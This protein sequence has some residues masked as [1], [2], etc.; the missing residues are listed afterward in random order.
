V[1]EKNIEMASVNELL[2]EQ[3]CIR[4]FGYG[5]LIWK[6]EFEYDNCYLGYVEGYERRFWQGNKHHRGNTKKPG[7]VLTLAKVENGHCWGVVFEITGTEKIESALSLLQTREC[8]LGGYE[9]VLVPVLV[10]DND[11]NGNKKS[12]I[13]ISYF[14]TP[15]N[16][17][18]LGDCCLD[19]MA[20]DIATAQGVCGYNCEYLLRMTDFMRSTLPQEDE[21]HLYDLDELVRMR[22][23]V[24]NELPWTSL[25]E[26]KSFRQTL[27]HVTTNTITCADGG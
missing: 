20:D 8:N 2:A 13:S 9:V 17:D 11:D 26:M 14:A 25:I 15:E 12:L 3:K 22:L 7:R 21:P 4:V 1:I 18:Y 6:P 27:F 19:D 24:D 5:S 10:P 16:D 23:G